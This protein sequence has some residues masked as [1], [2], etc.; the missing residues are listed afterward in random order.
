MNE[1]AG[2]REQAESR[3]RWRDRREDLLRICTDEITA[4]IGVQHITGIF[5]C[6]SFCTNEESV[7]FE[8]E[9]P[10]LLSDVDIVVVVHS[11]QV[12][13]E[14]FERRGEIGSACEDLIPDVRFVGHVEVGVLHIEEL[15]K[16]PPRPGVYDMRVAGRMLHG[17]ETILQ[18]I[19]PYE[20][21]RIG[22]RE[23]IVLIENRIIPHLRTVPAAVFEETG[24]RYRF[25]YQICRVY[26]DIATAALGLAG[27]YRTGYLNR[28]D[29][30][31][32][33]GADERLRSLV[34][35]AL[36]ER[37]DRWTGFKIIPSAGILSGAGGTVAHG[38]LWECSANDLLDTWM[39][40]EAQVQGIRPGDDA[41][42][43]DRLLG[44]RS[45]Y[46]TKRDKLRSWKAYL[47]HLPVEERLK[48]TV[49]L[50]KAFLTVGPLDLVREHGV[51]LLNHRLEDDGG[52]KV[53]SPPGS[54]PYSGGDWS[55]AVRD[56][57]DV[58][59]GIVFG[60]KG[61]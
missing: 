22:G 11:V 8:D 5:L 42:D 16:L 60:R 34:S 40:G 53:P 1:D 58:W 15:S 55:Q 36:L 35:E 28:L 12:L 59:A 6:G 17:D 30:L 61:A 56:L 27:Q 32:W 25:L 57:Y 41:G 29:L 50:G 24:D 23:S 49:R 51:R 4:S 45:F 31:K 3:H 52:S 48:L 43:I 33:S 7:V 47:S 26:T 54:F 44:S 21:S 20:P 9:K 39:K 37:I 46:V 14:V 18:H 19:P 13:R 10:F 2:I 38:D